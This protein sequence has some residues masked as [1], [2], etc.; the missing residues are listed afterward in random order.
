[1]I[2]FLSFLSSQLVVEL[3]F[4]VALI[5]A[6]KIS[7]LNHIYVINLLICHFGISF[8]F[9][10]ASKSCSIGMVLPLWSDTKIH[11]DGD[12]WVLTVGCPLLYVQRTKLQHLNQWYFPTFDPTLHLQLTLE[13]NM[14]RTKLC[15]AQGM[16]VVC[17]LLRGFTVNT[18]GRTHVFKP[19][20]VQA[21]WWVINSF[22]SHSCSL[23]TLIQSVICWH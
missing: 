6:K 7:D 3:Y 1:M 19:V 20:S 11:L 15:D 10:C 16:T 4:N 18:A 12:G 5:V 14:T 2:Q 21:M 17:L 23:K 13:F 9:S 8:A 22:W